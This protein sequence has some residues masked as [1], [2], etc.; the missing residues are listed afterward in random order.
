MITG[1]PPP[2]TDPLQESAEEATQHAAADPGTD[3][4]HQHKAIS[5]GMPA[6]NLKVIGLMAIGALVGAYVLWPRPS[7]PAEKKPIEVATTAVSPGSKIVEQLKGETRAQSAQQEAAAPA[8]PLFPTD[9][10]VVRDALPAPK[11]GLGG[12]SSDGSL[13]ARDY[14]SAAPGMPAENKELT[15][16]EQLTASAM[17]AS[18]VTLPSADRRKGRQETPADA[19]QSMTLA[20]DRQL[21]QMNKA[22]ARNNDSGVKNDAAAPRGSAQEEFLQKSADKTIEPAMSMVGVRSAH[23]LYQGTIIRVVLDR[24][25][26]TDTPGA[27]R[28]RVM[29]DVLDSVSQKTILIPRGST[30]VGS[31]KSS[32]LVGQARILIACERIILPNGKS[33]SLLGTPAADMQGA[34]GLPADVDNHFFEIFRA[35]FIVGAASLLLPKDQQNISQ[36][37]SPTGGSRTGGSILGTTLYDTIKQISERNKG[38]GPTG[39]IDLGEPFTL[40]LSRDIEMEPYRKL[41]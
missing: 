17:E 28:G 39:T 4:D 1:M 34:S 14:R 9:P 38:I 19:G 3:L 29:S 23:A 2:M 7:L 16:Q 13:L 18:E 8:S 36:S 26:N 15:R 27:I 32:M 30:L 11:A 6:R 41:N 40:M 22:M 5:R 24:A 20:L 37:E 10:A 12:N 21:A 33:I 31:Y 35:S 25:V